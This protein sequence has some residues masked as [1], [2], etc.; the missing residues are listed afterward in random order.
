MAKKKFKSV[1]PTDF[2]LGNID[3]SPITSIHVVGGSGTGK[4]H[5]SQQS[6]E[7]SSYLTAK[8]HIQH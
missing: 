3:E 7:R 6:L 5:S 4:A 8:G 1:W 2:A